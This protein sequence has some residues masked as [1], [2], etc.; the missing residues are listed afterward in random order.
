[1][2]RSWLLALLLLA[3]C[4]G[5]PP[6]IMARTAPAAALSPPDSAGIYVLPGENAPAGG[7]GALA[8]AMATALQQADVPASAQSSNRQ[9]YR[10]QPIVTATSSPDGQATIR[11]VWG[12]RNAAGKAVGSTSSGTVAATAAWQRGDDKL[13]AAL[14]A[15]AAP[16]VAK[17]IA[18][19]VSPPQG[20]L[21]PV[22]ALRP[23][24]GAP[25]DG[26]RSLTR[27]MSSALT[28]ANLTLA[29]VPSDKKDFIVAGTVEVSP[30]N[31]PQQQ[32]KVTWVL[33]RP[34]G[35]EIGRVKQ[36]NAVPAGSLDGAWGDVAYA[37]A[38]AAAPGV[39]RLIEEVGLTTASHS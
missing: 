10:L 17:L 11:V 16:I 4:N 19:D 20:S 1:M 25:G 38:G 33:M 14:A 18:G 30:A 3:A 12:L 31:G 27:A 2:R 34:D 22:V 5:A 35:S 15:P 21:N 13:A 29:A 6:P 23:I 28:R 32:V 39:R 8:A 24:A 9:S 26:D 7:A 37:V 36:E